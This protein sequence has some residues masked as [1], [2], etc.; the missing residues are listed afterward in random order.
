MIRD[1]LK[2]PRCGAALPIPGT[3]IAR[4]FP[5]HSCGQYLN[6]KLSHDGWVFGFSIVITFLAAYSY[7]LRSWFLLLVSALGWLPVFFVGRVFMNIYAHPRVEFSNPD[8]LSLRLKDPPS[9]L[10]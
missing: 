5:C 8:G 2:C 6:V 9:G 10:R 1:S 7:G 4:P 3:P